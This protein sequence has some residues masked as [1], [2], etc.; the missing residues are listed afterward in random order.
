MVEA[1][2]DLVGLEPSEVEAH[3]LDTG[4][5][6]GADVLLLAPG[7]D[8]DLATAEGLDIADDSAD[9][10]V[11]QAEGEVLVAEQS[12]LVACLGG[13]AEDEGAAQALDAMSQADLIVLLGGIEGEPDCDLLAW[14]QGLAGGFFGGDDQERDLAE[15]ELAIGVVRVE[16]VDLLDG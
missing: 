8:R 5:L 3:R 6:A 9:P 7:R 1:P 15:A 14:L 16:R 10:A 13:E 11:E 2:A 4:G 12:A